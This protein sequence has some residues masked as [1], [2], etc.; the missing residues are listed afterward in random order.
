M[1]VCDFGE[2][3][4]NRMISQKACHKNSAQH[5]SSYVNDVA[6]LTKKCLCTKL[7]TGNCV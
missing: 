5:G 4:R 7:L 3:G 6:I 1:K 2:D